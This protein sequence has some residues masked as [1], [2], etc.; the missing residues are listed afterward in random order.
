[1]KKLF[2]F[3]IFL[4]PVTALSGGNPAARTAGHPIALVGGTVYTLAGDPIPNG[5]VLFS[6]GKIIAA[7][8]SVDLPEGTEIISVKGKN[9][10]PALFAAGSVLGLREFE[11]VR[12]THDHAETGSNNADIRSEVSYNTDSEL[13]PVARSNGIAYNLTLPVG[14]L[15]AG[16]AS[17]M[18]LNGWTWEE[19]LIKANA[20]LVINWPQMS[21]ISAPWIKTPAE[22]QKQQIQKNL[23]ELRSAFEEARAYRKAK[24]AGKSSSWAYDSKWEGFFPVFDKKEPVLILADD[25]LQILAAI[26]FCKEQDVRMILVGGREAHKCLDVLKGNRIPVIVG[27]VFSV[28]EN[29]D[30]AYDQVYRLPGLLQANGIPFAIAN[31]NSDMSG[32]E[33]NLRNLPHEAGYAAGSGLSQTEAMKSITRYPAE[34]L[35]ISD[36]SGTLEPGKTAS[37]LVVD[38]NPL[39]VISQVEYL[40]IE[41]APIDLT[42]RQTRLRDQFQQRW[43]PEK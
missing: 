18:K 24:L 17:I 11:L 12:Q 6:N 15:L 4:I 36:H 13:I 43:K 8:P 10:Y 40:F 19:T 38:G 32:S 33:S 28:P 35:G 41:G 26:R 25:L 37:I 27:S 23:D 20:G 7:G 14:G 34:I 29:R 31:L 30:D 42:S 22:E 39:E 1:M 9:V 2:S 16:H 5:M 3:L 21:V